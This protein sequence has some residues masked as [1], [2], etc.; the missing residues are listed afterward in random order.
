MKEEPISLTI[1]VEALIYIQD[2]ITCEFKTRSESDLSSSN[3]LK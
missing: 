2:N 3:A 1:Q